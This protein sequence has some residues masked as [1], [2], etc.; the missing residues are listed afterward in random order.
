MKIAELHGRYQHRR[1]LASIDGASRICNASLAL[2]AATYELVPLGQGFRDIAPAVDVLERLVEESKLRHGD[3]PVLAMAAANAKVELD[4]AG[5]RK[6]SKRRSIGRIDPLVALAMALGVAARPAPVIDIA[7]IDRLERCRA[8]HTTRNGG[9][10]CGNQ[11]CRQIP[12]VR[13]VSNN[14]SG[15]SRR[16]RLTTSSPSKPVA[17]LIRRLIA[18]A[19]SAHHVIIVRPESSSSSAKSSR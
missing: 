13:R 15:S 17:N 16:P 6:L 12:F 9:S 5:N 10:G 4:A 11:A 14:T 7:A 1:S 3:H 18:C 2:S 8:G 19:R